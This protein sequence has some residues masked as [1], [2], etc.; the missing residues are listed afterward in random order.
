MNL[1]KSFLHRCL[2]IAREADKALDI[3]ADVLA[4]FQAESEST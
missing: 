1:R 4:G 2:S 3:F